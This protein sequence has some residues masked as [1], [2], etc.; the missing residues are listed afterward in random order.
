MTTIVDEIF[1]E[2]NR[3]KCREMRNGTLSEEQY[4]QW[5]GHAKEIWALVGTVAERDKW[6]PTLPMEMLGA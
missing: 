5:Q 1:E 2:P 3:E 6:Q 4:A